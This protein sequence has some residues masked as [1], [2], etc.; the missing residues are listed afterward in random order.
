MRRLRVIRKLD[1]PTY[2]GWA[3][4]DAYELD[5]KREAVARR[6]LF[7]RPECVQ[8]QREASVAGTPRSA[9]ARPRQ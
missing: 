4:I 3:W 7:V 1:W 9:A 2:D 5:A 6:S 8:Y